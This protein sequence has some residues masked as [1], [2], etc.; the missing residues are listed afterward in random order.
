M[1]QKN[2]GTTQGRPCGHHQ[3]DHRHPEASERGH[4]ALMAGLGLVRGSPLAGPLAG[5]FHS[6]AL[7]CCFAGRG[8]GQSNFYKICWDDIRADRRQELRS[9]Q[10]L[11][12]RSSCA[13]PMCWLAALTHCGEWPGPGAR[14]LSPLTTPPTAR[15][16]DFLNRCAA[17]SP[18]WHTDLATW[19]SP[20]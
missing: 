10:D 5:L 15:C 2:A 7:G 8:G 20:S 6:D 4:A 1:R 12:R 17:C 16:D 14:T 3:L 9:H 11:T 18:P 19:H 13:M